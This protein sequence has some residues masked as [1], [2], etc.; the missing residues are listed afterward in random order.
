M[1]GAFTDAKGDRIGRFE[2]AD[3]GTLFLDE[4]ANV[5][6]DQQA[7][8]LRVLETGELE[9]VGSSKTRTVDVRILSATNADL[10]TEVSGGRFREDL[11]FRLNTVEIRLPPLRDRPEDIP[12]L[13]MHFLGRVVEKYRK[14]ITGFD[15]AAMTALR[16]HPWPG[17]VRELAHVVERAVLMATDD[18]I[19]AD[20]L[21][22][23]PSGPVRSA[24]PGRDE[25]R[26]GGAHPDREGHAALRR[27]RQP[28]RRGPRAEPQRALPA[29][30]KAPA[31]S[32]SAERAE[33]LQRPPGRPQQPRA[34]A[35]RSVGPSGHR[36]R[37]HPA[38]PGRFRAGGEVRARRWSWWR[39]GSGWWPRPTPGPDTT[40]GP[41]RTCLPPCGRATTPSG[42][43]PTQARETPL[44]RWSPS[45]TP[46]PRRLRR[47]RVDDLE[48]TAL[49]RKVMGE[50]DVAVL[51]LRRVGTAAPGQRGRRA[52]AG[53][54][55]E[56]A[57]RPRRRRARSRTPASTG[58]PLAHRGA[59]HRRHPGRWEMRRGTFRQ[60]GRPHQ[61][62]VLSDVSRALR[63]EE[64]QAWKRLIR[65]IGHELNNSL[66]PIKSLAGSMERLL[67]RD[68]LPEDWRTDV[69]R[70]LD[71]ISSR[72]EALARF[73]SD[74][75]RLAKMPHPTR[76]A[77]GRGRLRAQ[78]GRIGDA[79]YR[80][81]MEAGRDV[82]A[83]TDQ[84]QIEQLLINLVRNAVE[85]SFETAGGVMCPLRGGPTPAGS[86]W[87]YRT[88]G[89]GL[90]ESAN[91]FVPFF[92]TKAEGSGIGLFLCRQ[93]AEAHG[94]NLSVRNRD[95]GPGCEARVRLPLHGNE[96]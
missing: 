55:T 19:R 47:Q 93:I 5:P 3:G 26:G 32:P 60:H 38:D 81:P 30:G 71:V 59:V 21:G 72:S 13:A 39:R 23:L 53:A 82:T 91:L 31:V 4:I 45:S 12:L 63:A 11:L 75:S 86:M 8:L 20:D 67:E 24:H 68:P 88:S 9:R 64:L 27:Q 61:L 17:N 18:T 16:R 70:G 29:A 95:N 37:L 85:A 22:L 69:R 78:G 62:V 84:D 54:S 28:G 52:A 44:A 7:K 34:P 79:A 40:C 56:D 49:V 58:P 10:A 94:G 46:W 87:W 89:P 76:H 50:I 51:R 65:V 1:R 43:R 90:P 6:L 96:D 74:C 36:A 73:M 25:P 33:R 41:S 80:G 92:T 48:A 66:A 77:G 2:M 35:G 83:E 57:H 14:A 15:E 42:L